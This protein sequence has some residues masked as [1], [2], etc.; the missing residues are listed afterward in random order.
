MRL[1]AVVAAAGD[2]SEVERL[3]PTLAAAARALGV[4]AARRGGVGRGAGVARRGADRH[5]PL[6]RG[7]P[8]A[9]S[10]GA[11]RAR[12][13]VHAARR[14]RGERAR[15]AGGG[16]RHPRCAHR[17]RRG[18]RGAGRAVQLSRHRARR[19]G[20]S[21]CSS[22]CARG[23]PRRGAAPTGSTATTTRGG[24]EARVDAAVARFTAIARRLPELVPEISAKIGERDG[25]ARAVRAAAARS[26]SARGDDV[27]EVLRAAKKMRVRRHRRVEGRARRRPTSRSRGADVAARGAA[28]QGAGAARRRRRRPN[29]R[30]LQAA[31]GRRRLLRSADDGARPL[32][33]R[34][35]RC[36]A[37][38]GRAST[39]CSSTSSR[40]PTRC[41]RRSC[42]WSAAGSPTTTARACSSS[43]IASSRS[44]S[45]AAPTWRC[46]RARPT[47]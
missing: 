43:A 5:L 36:A 31:R 2:A 11:R 29:Y 26:T 12:S 30:A 3:E 16:A 42:G 18:R 1:G 17:R 47:S 13:R 40:T 22:I 25:G 45:S 8:V 21:S 14:G 41:R 9:P 27:A 4:D 37:R 19:A 32:A 35:R 34:R 33:R 38:C 10:R 20:W 46:S 15:D 24:G 23:G 39:P 28:G 44:T 7:Q 6:V